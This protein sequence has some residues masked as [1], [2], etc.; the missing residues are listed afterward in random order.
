MLNILLIIILW[1]SEL[2]YKIFPIGKTPTLHN[3]IIILKLA[4]SKNKNNCYFNI[5][6]QKGLYED[7]SNT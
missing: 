4:V 6:L 7:K 2:I 3:V 5:L 1:K